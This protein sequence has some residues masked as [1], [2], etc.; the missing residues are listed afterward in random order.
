[1]SYVL[2]SQTW[3]SSVS[4][5]PNSDETADM[6][7]GAVWSKGKGKSKGSTGK[8]KNGDGET[9]ACF[10]CGKLGHLS[11]ACWFKDNSTEDGKGKGNGKG[12][13]KE[14]KGKSKGDKSTAVNA[15]GYEDAAT[16]AEVAN[17]DDYWWDEDPPRSDYE[18]EDDCYYRG[19]Q[20]L[21]LLGPAEG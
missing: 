10:A 6:E 18:V 13:H 21:S 11:S 19:Q 14:G 20:V 16:V 5:A 12:K 17:F 8:G 9:R 1:M 2:S 3:H 7:I 15:V 4:R